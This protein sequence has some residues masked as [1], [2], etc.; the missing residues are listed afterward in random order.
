MRKLAVVVVAAVVGGVL[1]ACGTP[2]QPV[3]ELRA[4]LARTQRLSRQFTYEEVTNDG[5][6]TT[7]QGVIE[8]DFR[9]RARIAVN[10]KPAFD[11]VVTDD[12]I[13]D[14]FLDPQFITRMARRG[15]PPPSAP[16]EGAAPIAQVRDA[17]TTGNWVVDPGGAPTL[18]AGASSVRRTLGDDPIFDAQ[19]VFDYVTRVA[20]VMP[21]RK[22]NKDALDYKPKEDPFPK[23]TKASGVLRY[24]VIRF[25]VPRPSD[26][27]SGTQQ[28][29]SEV[30][31]RKLAVYVKK[32]LVIRVLEDMDVASRLRDI[33]RNYDV[34]LEGNIQER[35]SSAIDAIN[36]VRRAQGTTEPIRVRKMSLRLSNV[37]EPNV[38]TAPE[39]TVIGDLSILINRGRAKTSAAGTPPGEGGG[40]STD[41]GATDQ[42][43][44]DTSAPAAP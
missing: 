33:Q 16:P 11:E 37:G 9:Y 26:T 7:V 40:G 23:P 18:V 34:R 31:F 35:I 28:L 24:D 15:P 14:R 29:P 39:T 20:R 42:A 22:F 8:D 43:T 27:G 32:G 30:H 3:K 44:T 10:D 13:A 4:A 36:V 1:P 38:V 12:A 25:P 41:E 17:L 2:N 6:K 19:T 5:Q 21:V